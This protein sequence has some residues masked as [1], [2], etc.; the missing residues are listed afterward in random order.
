MKKHAPIWQ[1]V[2]RVCFH[3][4]ENKSDPKFPFAFLATY[5]PRLSRAGQVQYQPLGR[6]LQEYA[7]QRN[8]K[9]LISLLSPVQAASEKSSF[10]RKLVDSHNVFHPLAWSPKDAYRFLRDV[11]ILEESG[12][13]VRVPD[14]WQKRPRPRVAVTMGE[15]KQSR[16]GADTMLDFKVELA[17]GSD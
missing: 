14:W 4:A 6:A 3:L 15:K 11:P 1:Q 13:L 7:G 5:A 2:G 8:K 17:L 12:L 10:I 9:A 16:I